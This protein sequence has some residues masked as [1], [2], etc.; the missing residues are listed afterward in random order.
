MRGL[1][2]RLRGGEGGF[3]LPMALGILVV[4]TITVTTAT[5]P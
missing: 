1:L 3:V 5:R 2:H 4:L